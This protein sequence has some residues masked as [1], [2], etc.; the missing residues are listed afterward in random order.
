M[1]LVFNVR[2]SQWRPY[3]GRRHSFVVCHVHASG[4][5]TLLAKRLLVG[6][7]VYGHFDKTAT[8]HACLGEYECG[9][10][11]LWHIGARLEKVVTPAPTHNAFVPRLSTTRWGGI[12]RD[13]IRQQ[14]AGYTTTVRASRARSKRRTG[15]GEGGEATAEYPVRTERTF[16]QDECCGARSSI[17]TTMCCTGCWCHSSKFA[18]GHRYSFQRNHNRRPAFRNPSGGGHPGKYWNVLSHHHVEVHAR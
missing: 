4:V 3:V 9:V 11:P 18:W 2:G 6:Y 8:K 14:G 16:S 1:G 12:R 17:G 7:R 5:G 13:N 10:T 15:H